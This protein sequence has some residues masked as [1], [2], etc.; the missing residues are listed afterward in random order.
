[1]KIIKKISIDILKIAIISSQL[2]LYLKKINWFIFCF[3]CL[4]G[5]YWD[6]TDAKP[7][8]S[9]WKKKFELVNFDNICFMNRK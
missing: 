7:Q 4:A 9:K 5:Q 1:M 8:C 2:T 3:R 6:N